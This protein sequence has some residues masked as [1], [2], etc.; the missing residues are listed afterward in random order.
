MVA[1]SWGFESLPEHQPEKEV[2]E[3]RMRVSCGLRA[4]LPG[5]RNEEVLTLFEVVDKGGVRRI[6]T[7][8]LSR[9][10]I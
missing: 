6:P 8:K 7:E 1:T 3:A 10:R 4:L 2:L 5:R 9:E